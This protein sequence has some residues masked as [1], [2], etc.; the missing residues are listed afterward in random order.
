MYVAYK[1]LSVLKELTGTRPEQMTFC[2]G[3]SKGFL[4]PQILADVFGIP[5]KVPRV[6][7]STAFGC[8]M[9]VGVGTGEFNSFHDAVEQWV[10][11]DKVFQPNL[12]VHEEYLHFYDRWRDV[13]DELLKLVDK[14]LLRPMWKAPGV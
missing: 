8:G 5:V 13:L 9:C 1:N 10:E 14:E 12:N 6:K 2:G 3:S 4:W 11:T 7:E